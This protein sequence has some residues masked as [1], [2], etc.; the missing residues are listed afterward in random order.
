MAL[1]FNLYYS[2]PPDEMRALERVVAAARACVVSA[3]DE[4][5]DGAAASAIRSDSQDLATTE[6]EDALSVLDALRMRRKGDHGPRPGTLAPWLYEYL[7][8]SER[9]RT[10]WTPGE[11]EQTPGLAST[12]EPLQEAA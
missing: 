6:L 12:N 7:R 4:P 2:V 1:G 9:R 3:S 5:G 11:F 8:R 10:A